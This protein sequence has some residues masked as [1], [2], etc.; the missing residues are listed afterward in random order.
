DPTASF[1]DLNE[2]EPAAAFSTD[3]QDV[4]FNIVAPSDT[5]AASAPAGPEEDER[6]DSMMRQEL[7]R[8][9]F[10]IAQGYGDI[11]VDTLEMLEKQFGSHPD[12]QA[13]RDKLAASRDQQPQPAVFE[14]GGVEELPATPA[15]ESIT[16]DADAAYAPV[17]SAGVQHDGNNAKAA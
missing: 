5:Q 2:E 4:D 3:F 1:A 14:F 17:A 13:R 9:E 11:A 8:V 16:F 15:P 12:I 10:Y 6:R 7:E